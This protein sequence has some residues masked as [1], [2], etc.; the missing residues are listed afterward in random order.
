MLT[1]DDLQQLG[2]LFDKK[3]DEKLEPINKRLDGLERGQMQLK[4]QQTKQ[5]KNIAHIRKTV[6]ILVKWTDEADVDLQHRIS[7]VEKVLDLPPLEQKH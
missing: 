4:K 7:R 6:D 5:G 1:Q 2:Q 3:M